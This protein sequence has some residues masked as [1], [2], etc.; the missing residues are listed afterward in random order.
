MAER[1][2]VALLSLFSMMPG[3]CCVA[4]PRR[5]IG[6]LAVCGCGIPL[7]CSLFFCLFVCFV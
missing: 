5:A 4:L 2:L 6:L 1:E 3:D 7:S